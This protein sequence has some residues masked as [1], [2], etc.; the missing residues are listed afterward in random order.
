[1]T[2]GAIIK[3]VIAKNIFL[4]TDF[5]AKNSNG[6]KVGGREDPKSVC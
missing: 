5:P 1:M 3:P 6:H 2:L 4:G